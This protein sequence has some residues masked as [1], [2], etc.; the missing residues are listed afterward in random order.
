LATNVVINVA[1]H[2]RG[3]ATRGDDRLETRG[4]ALR[5]LLWR[6]G[7]A[8]GSGC[9]ATS[10]WQIVEG[11][12]PIVGWG[13]PPPRGHPGRERWC[14]AH[15][16]NVRRWL[17]D[18]QDGGL[19]SFTAEPDNR[20]QDWRTIITLHKAPEPPADELDAAT[21]RKD[22]WQRRRR[23]AARAR[24]KRRAPSRG[25]RLEL[26][27]RSSQRPQKATRRRLA[28]TRACALRDRRAAAAS[29]QQSSLCASELRTHHFIAPPSSE[30]FS[31][32]EN[33]ISQAN[34]CTARSRVTRTHDN[35]PNHAVAAS[36]ALVQ[37]AALTEADV[38]G[39]IQPGLLDGARCL[40]LV[41]ERV[42]AAEAARRPRVELIA[43]HAQR[44][45]NEVAVSVVGR[46]WPAWRLQE[47]WVVW[48]HDALL[49]GEHHGG[50]AGPLQPGDVVLLQRAAQRYEDNASTRPAG[51]PA[52]G[53]AALRQLAELARQRDV[54]PQILHYAI[55]ALEQLSR[56]MH[57][58]ATAEDPERFAKQLARARRRRQPPTQGPL[59]FR[60]APAQS[61]WPHWLTLDEHGA[62][63]L[64]DGELRVL[65]VAG[66]PARGD[67]RY[68]EALRD[69][70][71]LAGLRPPPH[72]DGRSALGEHAGVYD[73]DLGHRRAL[74]PPYP[75]PKHARADSD[76]ADRELARLTH[77]DVCVARRLDVDERDRRLHDARAT[78]ADAQRDDHD[79]FWS[80]IHNATDTSRHR[81]DDTEL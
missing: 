39:L 9:Y 79:A 29:A 2:A 73:P 17:E 13:A 57:A 68:R 3:C 71:L 7:H 40:E 41:A 45:A 60:T 43:E 63:L 47:A 26:I 78:N 46:G 52:G 81:D 72:A 70:Y 18:L 56:R 74:P 42:A 4:N 6:W 61:G 30:P 50:L 58:I 54:R 31:E 53:Y 11:L 66:A 24:R 28:I 8:K 23:A 5:R 33:V 20:G 49:V 36:T 51:W 59:Q 62:P 64:C 21:R 12:A 25:R 22:A 35:S 1:R 67:E 80:H 69:A 48:R 15:A 37:T 16:E 38:D 44:R 14:R 65:D 19:I 10:V 27:V 55:C 77:T 32:T 76:P 75:A 34:A